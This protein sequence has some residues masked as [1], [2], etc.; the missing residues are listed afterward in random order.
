[1]KNNEKITWMMIG[2][3][4]AGIAGEWFIGGS[5]E[6]YSQTRNIFVGAQLIIGIGIFF[7][8]FLKKKN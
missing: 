1:M 5:Y 4:V 3:L 2:A 6:S 7:Y 8:P